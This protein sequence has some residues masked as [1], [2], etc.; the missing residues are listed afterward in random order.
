MEH[1]P[2]HI[3]IERPSKSSRKWNAVATN[4]LKLIVLFL[5]GL[6]ILLALVVCFP[7]LGG[8][9]PADVFPWAFNNPVLS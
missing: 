1:M 5:I 7:D 9:I 8:I 6:V 4:D 2:T 3:S